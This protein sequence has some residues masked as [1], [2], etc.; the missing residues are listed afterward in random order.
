MMILLPLLLAGPTCAI[1]AQTIRSHDGAAVVSDR[2]IDGTRVVRSLQASQASRSA[3]ARSA[4]ARAPAGDNAVCG[5]AALDWQGQPLPAGESGTLDPLAFNHSTTLNNHGRIAFAAHVDGAARNQGVFVSDTDGL[6][7]IALGCGS[8]GGG[9]APDSCG[10]PSPIGGTFSGFFLDTFATPD[11]NDNGDVLFI[12]DVDGGSSTRGLFLYQAGSDS[13]VKI[14][15]VGDPSPLGGT[16]TVIGPGNLN[17]AGTIAFLAV[18]DDGQGSDIL[19]WQDGVVSKYVAAGDAAP[20]GGTFTLLGSE[21]WGYVDGT[22]LAG[23]P[24][25]GINESGQI[26]F[27][28]YVDGGIAAGGLFLSTGGKHEWLLKAGD[29][30]PGG[31]SFAD[32][33]APLLNNNG[34]IAFYGSIKGGSTGIWVTG[35]PGNW[36]RVLAFGDQIGGGTIDGMAVSRNPMHALADNGDLVLWSTRLMPDQSDLGTALVHHENGNV[37]LIAVQRDDSPI[38]GIWGGSMNGWPVINDA[39]QVAIGSATP[40]FGDAL[41]ADVLLTLCTDDVLFRDGFDG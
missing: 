25:P 19:L 34:E 21:L 22:S 36:R 6:H 20:G 33:D 10:D 24:A 38:G 31:S 16:I 8:Y 12:A 30:A 14:I 3:V 35:T 15:A 4:V 28:G 41:S 39:S 17:N 11:I 2:T 7:A 9:G 29:D 5:A 1:Q 26:S 18:T 40:G 32:F 27:R 23:G 37:D 13:I